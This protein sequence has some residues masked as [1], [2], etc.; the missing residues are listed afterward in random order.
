MKMRK[1]MRQLIKKGVCLS[2]RRRIKND[3]L[4]SVGAKEVS[5]EA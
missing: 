1:R 3:I 2:Q 4:R 5:R